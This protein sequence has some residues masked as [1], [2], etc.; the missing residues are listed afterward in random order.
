[1]IPSATVVRTAVR[2]LGV[3]PVAPARL[4]A[5]AAG[6]VAGSLPIARTAT[7]R[8]NL[9]QLAP[10]HDRRTRARLARR[11]F[12]N[13]L[14]A[15]VDLWRLPTMSGAALDALVTVEGREHLDA[16]LAL[17]KGVVAVTPHLG[18]YELGGAWLAHAGYPVHAMVEVLDAQTNAAMARYREA[19]GMRLI[20]RSAGMR[21]V[22]RLLRER[23]IVLLVADRV[24]GEGAEGLE[25]PFGR[26]HR[27]IPTGPAA[28]C[29][30][31]GAPLLVGYITRTGG[32][33][34]RY[35]IRFE[36]AIDVERT[37]DAHHDRDRLT[38]LIGQ[39][40]SAVA[41]AHPDE[42]FVFQPDWRQRE[43]SSRP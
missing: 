7:L 40:L 36:P 1:M 23:Q 17:G 39:R 24:V 16:A 9:A 12:A 31:T 34:A 32:N 14:D 35:V 11:T 27:A 13:L 38:R 8:E 25:V 6:F 42:W 19:T 28:L 26:G 43:P 33:R 3:V 21:P 5:R 2:L 20:P 30:A 37:G 22:L 41:Q 29:I 10:Q 18:P 4:L 15:A